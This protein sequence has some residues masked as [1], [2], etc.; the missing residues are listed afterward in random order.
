MLVLFHPCLDFWQHLYKLSSPPDLFLYDP[1]SCACPAH[2]QS[3]QYR[4]PMEAMARYISPMY[5]WK[6]RNIA[7]RERSPSLRG[8]L[9]H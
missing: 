3:F 6:Y 9:G 2:V 7:D 5:L 4:V 8:D 1:L